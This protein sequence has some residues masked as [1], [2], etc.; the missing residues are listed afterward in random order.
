MI[1]ELQFT[2]TSI[3]RP[4]LVFDHPVCSSNRL[5]PSEHLAPT[6]PALRQENAI[7]PEL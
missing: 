1:R 5:L 7:L 6:A 2:G 4:S 3:H